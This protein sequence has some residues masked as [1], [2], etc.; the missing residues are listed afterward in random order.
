MIF[1]KIVSCL[2][3]RNPIV[4]NKY[5]IKLAINILVLS[6]LY[7]MAGLV[8]DKMAFHSDASNIQSDKQGEQYVGTDI[9]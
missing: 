4:K 8:F 2:M 6:L 5:L 9:I 7:G 3:A 1:Y